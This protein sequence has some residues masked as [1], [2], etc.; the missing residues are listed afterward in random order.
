MSLLSNVNKTL[1]AIKSK[2]MNNNDLTKL[3]FYS[4]PNPLEEDDLTTS[5]KNQVITLN[6]IVEYNTD[7]NN[8][9]NHFISIGVPMIGFGDNLEGV[10]IQ[11]ELAIVC[12]V[13]YWELNNNRLRL[14]TVAEKVYDELNEKKFSL[15]GKLIIDGLTPEIFRD[16]LVGY[17]LTGFIM[18]SDLDIELE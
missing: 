14:M 3:L 2:L 17:R 7:P 10:L 5:Q 16:N 1:Y 6:P 13:D 8:T 18:D 11:I 12:H 4:V 15:S 9:I